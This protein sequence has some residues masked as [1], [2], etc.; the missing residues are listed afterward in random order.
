MDTGS[1]FVLLPFEIAEDIGCEP[2]LDDDLEMNCAC[3]GTF[4]TYGSR[5]PIELIV[6]HPGFRPRSWQTHVR[7]VNAKVPPLLGQR[8]FLDRLDVTFRGKLH[9]MSI[10]IDE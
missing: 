7:L 9:R 5:Y 8:G 10:R 3:G 6:D 1:D 2:D 4:Q